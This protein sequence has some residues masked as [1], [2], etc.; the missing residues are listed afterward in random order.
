MEDIKRSVQQTLV[1]SGRKSLTLNCVKN[2][3]SL[4]EGYV[5]LATEAGTV[6]V[7]G[8]GLKIESLSKE[9]G[10][11]LIVGRI[12]AVYYNDDIPKKHSIFSRRTK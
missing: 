3:E 4:D 1:L 9:G 7:E 12:S 8:E 6:G 11:V 2:V 10:N 5:S